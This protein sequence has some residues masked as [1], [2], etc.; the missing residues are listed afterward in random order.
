MYI[1]VSVQIDVFS[2][3]CIIVSIQ[4]FVLQR[5]FVFKFR[6]VCCFGYYI[7]DDAAVLLTWPRL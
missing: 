1:V 7:G 4:R 2:D 6:Q 3:E 5:A